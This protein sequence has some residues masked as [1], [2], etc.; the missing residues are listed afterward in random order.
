MTDVLDD[1]KKRLALYALC[2]GVLMIVLDTTIVIVALPSIAETL[3]ASAASLV[4]IVNLYTLTFGGFLLLSGRLGDLYGRRR[5]F[6][7]GVV[8][9]TLASLAC[10]LAP[11]ELPLL[12]ARAIQG[13]AGAIVTSVSLSLV[14]TLFPDPAE[15]A[16]AM[17]IYG[18]VQAVGGSTGELLGGVL[19]NAFGWHSIF[20]VNLPIGIAVAALCFVLLPQDKGAQQRQRLDL[21]GAIVVTVGL[22]VLT[23]GVVRATDGGWASPLTLELLG[24]GAILL[25]AFVI[26]ESRVSEPLMPLRLFR[27]RNFSATNV[28]GAFWS[29]GQ[30]AWFVISALYLQRVLGYDPFWVGIAF[31]PSQVI[32]ATFYAGLAAKMVIRFGIREPLWIGLI[33]IAAGLALFARAPVHGTFALDVIPAMLLLGL[34]AGMASTP[35]LLAAMHDV[36]NTESGLASGVVNTSCMMGGALGLAI[37]SALADARTRELLR[38]GVAATPAL[39]GGYHLAFCSAA[40]LTA[41]AAFLAAFLLHYPSKLTSPHPSAVSG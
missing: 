39:N 35:L 5:L 12:I 28:L 34:G 1:R 2:V 36:P 20:L 38:A 4:W 7:I 31:V 3:H 29:A 17:G 26:I 40:F 22:T 13:L 27:L 16:K 14:S 25:W 18:L 23:A 6:L 30:Y 41:L 11:S 8:T 19:T 33:L 24:S 21:T 32:T 9:F 37:L 10:G 15:R